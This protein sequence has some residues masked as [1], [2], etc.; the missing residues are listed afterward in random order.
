[1]KTNSW[2]KKATRS[3]V[4]DSA[5]ARAVV[6]VALAALTFAC[7]A[8]SSFAPAESPPGLGQL[9]RGPVDFAF[10]SLDAR[11]VSGPAT[12]GKPTILSFV[13]TSSL[14]AQA[15]VD[16]LVAMAKNDGDLVN[17]AVV[18]L[19]RGDNRELVEMYKRALSIPFP[20]AM[21]DA[22]T[23]AGA[24]AFGD[25]SAVPVTVV[26]DR[27]GRVVSRIDG[28]VAKSAELRAAMRGL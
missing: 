7:T 21:A 5:A 25:L 18:S 9:A 16:F 23:L 10:D 3:A 24:G 26:L 8:G 4:D 11:P 27:L 20:V 17:Y 13:A 15:Q 2:G 14:P 22:Q 6:V 1:M 19:D 12:R 28:R